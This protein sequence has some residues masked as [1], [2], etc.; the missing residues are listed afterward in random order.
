MQIKIYDP[1][2][3]GNTRRFLDR[4][5]TL[6]TEILAAALLDLA[7]RRPDQPDACYGTLGNLR[8]GDNELLLNL[9]EVSHIFKSLH[10]EGHFLVGELVI[11]NRTPNG[12]ILQMLMDSD[13]KIVAFELRGFWDYDREEEKLKGFKLANIAAVNR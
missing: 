9:S 8:K 6:T 3:P 7:K 1:D 12:Q 11:L 10:M 5:L 2:T 4:R 13:P